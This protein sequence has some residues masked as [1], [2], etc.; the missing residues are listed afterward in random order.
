MCLQAAVQSSHVSL[1]SLSH[2]SCAIHIQAAV[3]C[4]T[5]TCVPL[6][7]TVVPRL[8]SE[9]LVHVPLLVVLVL[10]AHTHVLQY[11]NEMVLSEFITRSEHISNIGISML[12][13]LKSMLRYKLLTQPPSSYLQLSFS[14]ISYTLFSP[15]SVC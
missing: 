2:L 8:P 3:R 10:S 15:P 1:L 6:V 4:P 7:V 5:I 9:G 13:S 14:T 12:L 11:R